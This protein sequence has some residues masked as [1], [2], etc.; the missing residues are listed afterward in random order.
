M[1]KHE[2][3]E[4]A[5]NDNE[6]LRIAFEG[7]YHLFLSQDTGIMSLTEIQRQAIIVFIYATDV[8]RGGHFSFLDLNFKKIGIQAVID[9][10]KALNI[11]EKY[12]ENL[13]PIADN[14]IFPD[15]WPKDDEQYESLYSRISDLLDPLNKL[16]YE[17]AAQEEFINKT[18]AY[19]KNNH[20]EFF[21][22]KG[23]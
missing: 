7:F 13:T 10:L 18:L 11:N 5:L 19:V 6:L 20:L 4:S 9:S 23:G 22:I 8:W 15:E 16:L 1:L 17:E 14:F 2:I 3:T 21:E 12:I